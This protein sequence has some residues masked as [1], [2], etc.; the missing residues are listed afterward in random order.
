MLHII[1]VPWFLIIYAGFVCTPWLLSKL[2]LQ[3]PHFWFPYSI[4]F[5]IIKLIKVSNEFEENQLKCQF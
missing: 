5:L 1:F 2:Q 4:G 3:N